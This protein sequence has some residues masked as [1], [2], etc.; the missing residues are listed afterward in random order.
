VLDGRTGVLVGEQSAA[1][2]QTAIQRF[3]G[4]RLDEH[5]LRKN[6]QR[7]SRAHF[8]ARMADVIERALRSFEQ[9]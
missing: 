2:F 6:A 8:R 5:E 3:E 7:F 1:G 4:L 9:G